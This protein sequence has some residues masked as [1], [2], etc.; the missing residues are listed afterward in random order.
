MPTQSINELGNS[1][2][3]SVYP[4]PATDYLYLSNADNIISYKIVNQFG[5]EVISSSEIINKIDVSGLS[6]GVF[7]AG[8][9]GTIAASN[10][11]FNV[12]V[13]PSNY[14]AEYSNISV[15]TSR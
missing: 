14:L 11:G 12:V 13:N 15:L 10:T 9:N 2:K 3:L 7:Q 6:N 8:Y 5:Q 4:N 1:Q